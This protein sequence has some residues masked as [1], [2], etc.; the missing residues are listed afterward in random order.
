M[1]QFGEDLGDTDEDEDHDMI[2][3]P[4]NGA[5]PNASSG[6]ITPSIPLETASEANA[7]L[8]RKPLWSINDQCCIICQGPCDSTSAF[9]LLG[10]VQSSRMVRNAPMQY[11][12]TVLKII[13]E[14]TS[15]DT[16]IDDS[17]DNWPSGRYRD[18]QHQ[19]L[20]AS[21]I[22]S[23]AT[24]P[25][26]YINGGK[27]C[28]AL[29][30]IGGFPPHYQS[31]GMHVSTCNHSMHLTCF[32]EYYKSIEHTHQQ[33]LT[34]NHPESLVRHEYL[35]PLCRNL[36]NVLIPVLPNSQIHDPL[37][38]VEG[39]A[40]QDDDKENS[41]YEEWL[42]TE[43]MSFCNDIHGSVP[44]TNHVLQS[45]T[46]V[47]SDH[48]NILTSFATKTRKSD[49]T[50]LETENQEP[51]TTQ[52]S[53]RTISLVDRLPQAISISSDYLFN[54][55]Q[56]LT[57]GWQSIIK[58]INNGSTLS[59]SSPSQAE[60]DIIYSL[61][62]YIVHTS[63]ELARH[64]EENNPLDTTDMK[65]ISHTNLLAG[66]ANEKALRKQFDEYRTLYLH[67]HEI[68]EITQ[69]D[70]KSGLMYPQHFE[71]MLK[72][73][74]SYSQKMFQ[75]TICL[76]MKRQKRTTKPTTKMLKMVKICCR[77]HK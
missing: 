15:L 68:F 21:E 3:K 49:T 70:Y 57:D 7:K 76:M 69:E 39:L 36:G 12:D 19:E 31:R 53:C 17:A 32:Q 40:L 45:Q 48:T 63:P 60:N 71:H 56:L 20:S 23:Q 44:E 67:L 14:N 72:N 74:G 65:A 2:P 28:G 46:D 43:W 37:T 47:F 30:T 73:N 64:I 50:T 62:R 41:Q 9:G 24:I 25:S 16:E 66:F 55:Q 54:P 33:Q 34:R 13:T 38:K 22:A 5:T 75:I 35:C 42:N 59:S 77:T 1:D 29:S 18:S 11:A 58:R 61:E 4:T 51:S 10:L 52:T 6:N 8:H 26:G 27:A